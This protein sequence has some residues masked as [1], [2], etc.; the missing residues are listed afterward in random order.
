MTLTEQ[1]APAHQPETYLKFRGMKAS[2]NLPTIPELGD[3]QT[4]TVTAE[5]VAVGTEK[6]ADG[7]RRPVIGM[8]VLEV[9][10]G[11]IEK[12]PEGDPQLP[13][14]DDEEL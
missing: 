13:L 4:Y 2:G 3:V 6:R 5:C 9:E 12:A 7:E 1:P 14:G 11:D 8:K 10:P